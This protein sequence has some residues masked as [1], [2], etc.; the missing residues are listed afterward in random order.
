MRLINTMT[1]KHDL[2]NNL[3]VQLFMKPNMLPSLTKV[4]VW[5]ISARPKK[6]EYRFFKG[7]ECFQTRLVQGQINM[8]EVVIT[9]RGDNQKNLTILAQQITDML[10]ELEDSTIPNNWMDGVSWGATMDG[11]GLL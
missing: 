10:T 7:Y 3:F 6:T 4:E 5:E 2:K 11:K 8:N 1:D 9:I